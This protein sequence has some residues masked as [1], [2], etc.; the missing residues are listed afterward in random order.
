MDR[1]YIPT[2][3]DNLYKV[4]EGSFVNRNNKEY[5]EYKNRNNKMKSLENRINNIEGTLNQML[6]ILKG[7]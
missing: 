7:K 6:E 2:D 3:V 5:E 1:K 4:S